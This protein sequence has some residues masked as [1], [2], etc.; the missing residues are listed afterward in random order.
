MKEFNS[1]FLP[2]PAFE[3]KQKMINKL[4]ILAKVNLPTNLLL[5]VNES[6]PADRKVCEETAQSLEMML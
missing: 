1:K 6:D 4:S 5:L 2:K 3:L